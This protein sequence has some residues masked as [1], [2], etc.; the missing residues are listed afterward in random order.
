MNQNNSFDKITNKLPTH[1][2]EKAELLEK[3]NNSLRDQIKEERFYWLLVFVIVTN[4]FVFMH[5]STWG[6]PIGIVIL[7]SFG[8]IAA[9]RK[10]QVDTVVEV[11]DRILEGW[12]SK[13]KQDNS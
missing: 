1:A 2:D 9:A 12:V 7:E 4:M 8:L 5:M 10:C 11:T 13:R 6:G 3:E